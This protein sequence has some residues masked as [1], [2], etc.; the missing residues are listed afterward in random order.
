MVNFTNPGVLGN[1]STFRKYYEVSLSSSREFCPQ[2]VFA[3]PD[4]PSELQ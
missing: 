4:L 1:A 3:C 2:D